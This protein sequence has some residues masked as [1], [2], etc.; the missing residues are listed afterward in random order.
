MR[1]SER[2]RLVKKSREECGQGWR[3]LFATEEEVR[4][5]NGGVY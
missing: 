5:G 4:F 3:S 1:G 2:V